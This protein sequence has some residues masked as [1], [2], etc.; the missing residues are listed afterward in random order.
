MQTLT[1]LLAYLQCSPGYQVFQNN[2]TEVDF[3]QDLEVMENLI[4]KYVPN[5]SL[6]KMFAEAFPIDNHPLLGGWPELEAFES[7]KKRGKKELDNESNVADGKNGVRMLLLLAYMM[8]S[9]VK[10]D[11]SNTTQM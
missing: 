9:N 7:S 6:C 10:D 11:T 4:E 8:I 1:Y 2:K 3:H 5:G